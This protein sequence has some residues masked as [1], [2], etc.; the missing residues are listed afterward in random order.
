MKRVEE[1]RFDLFCCGRGRGAKAVG[2]SERITPIT[3]LSRAGGEG[4]FSLAKKHFLALA[5]FPVCSILR[6]VVSK[7]G[8]HLRFGGLFC[9]GRGRGVQ[10]RRTRPGRF[11][12]PDIDLLRAGGK[13]LWPLLFTLAAFFCE[14]EGFFECFGLPP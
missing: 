3:G 8:N 11:E 9:Y 7:G 5:Q 13:N 14:V 1:F 6:L 2:R 10:A 4:A 12:I